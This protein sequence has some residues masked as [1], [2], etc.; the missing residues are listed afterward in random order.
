MAMNRRRFAAT[1]AMGAVGAMGAAGG[2]L[3]VPAH[4]Q[5][6]AWPAHPVR[7][8]V[9]FPAGSSPDIIART[10]GEP[11]GKLL[12][13]PVVIDNRTGASGNIAADLVSKATDDHTIGI[14]INGN[15]TTA[16]ALDK[17]LP[18][19]PDKDFTLISL[20]VT[21]PLVLVAPADMPEGPAFAEKARA[22]GDQWSYG[23]V[24]VG[25]TGH[26]GMEYMKGKLPGMNAVH[27]PFPGN[28][29]VVTA[30]LG[31][32]IQLAL[33]PPSVAMPQVKA[34]KL[35]AI[36]L[37][38]PRTPLVPGVPSLSEAGIKDFTF[39]VWI[40]LVGPAQLS[41]A[42]KSRITTELGKVM[43]SEDVKQKLF[44]LGF[45]AVGSSSADF[46]AR[47]KRETAIMGKLIADKNISLK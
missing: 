32:Q 45:T 43:H 7:M 26:L 9:G 4:A 29:Q 39:E 33:V 20:L 12:G 23:S 28:P 21:S 13:Q 27:V 36:G 17:N 35:K 16:K 44:Q 6:A 31:G 15:L 25:S 41:E 11:L 34:G 24:G 30:L 42:A 5:T 37:A 3:A 1:A 2:L 38:G 46:Q 10:V 19:D 8:V 40:A 14:V 47:V 18:F 22:S